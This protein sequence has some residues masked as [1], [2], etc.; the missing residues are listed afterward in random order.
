MAAKTKV[1]IVGPIT[2]EN[3]IDN[4]Y[5]ANDGVMNVRFIHV[6]FNKDR[7]FFLFKRQ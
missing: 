5:N 2:L 6:S 7:M 1:A 3:I 4:L